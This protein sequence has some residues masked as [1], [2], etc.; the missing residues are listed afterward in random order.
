MR[1][2]GERGGEERE[3]KGGRGKREGRKEGEGE[4]GERGG[5]GGGEERLFEWSRL[6]CFPLPH[7]LHDVRK[8]HDAKDPLRVVTTHNRK[9]PAGLSQALQHG[10]GWM[11]RVRVH[12]VA[13]EQ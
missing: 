4:G 10:L 11:I 3:R 2:E 6:P 7:E 9:N 8:C 12:N 1:G 5:S 13:V